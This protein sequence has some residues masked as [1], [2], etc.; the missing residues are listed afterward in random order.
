VVVGILDKVYK[1]IFFMEVVRLKQENAILSRFFPGR[2][3]FIAQNGVVKYLDLG[4]RTKSGKVYRSKM[5][6]KNF[7]YSQPEVYIV[8]PNPI[9]DKSG[10]MLSDIGV[11][12]GMHLL[13]PDDENN[14]QL[15]HY[16]SG[17]WNPNV[18]LYKVAIKALIWLEA[19]E[20]HLKT[21]NPIDHY[22][23]HKK[24]HR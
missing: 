24:I 6:L 17:N 12:A 4:M 2:F 11:S 19:Y 22:L 16:V 20:G 15:C 9:Y 13:T 7:P 14:I 8:Y 3:N 1:I 23:S 18:T 21:G 10:N 5:V